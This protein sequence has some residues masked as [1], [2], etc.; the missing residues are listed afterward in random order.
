MVF[1][2]GS[3]SHTS[4]ERRRRAFP[5]AGFRHVIGTL[6]EVNDRLAARVSDRFYASLLD[7]TDRVEDDRS[8]LR[9]T[10][11]CAR[12]ATDTSRRRLCGQPMSMSGR[13][14]LCEPQDMCGCPANRR[15]QV[16]EEPYALRHH[17]TQPARRVAACRGARRAPAGGVQR[18]RVPADR[19]PIGQ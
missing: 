9:C 6:W 17:P 19:G 15:A 4:S 7:L 2:V 10:T 11:R 5:L 13:D 18:R 8:P 1:A 12:N 16:S 3:T 14:P